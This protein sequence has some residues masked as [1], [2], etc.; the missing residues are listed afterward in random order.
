M[1]RPI[2]SILAISRSSSGSRSTG[3][4]H[5]I[6]A[7]HAIRLEIECLVQNLIA[8]LILSWHVMKAVALVGLGGLTKFVGMRVGMRVALVC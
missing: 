3:A 7:L 1:S 2:R 4:A 8:I 6:H 5:S